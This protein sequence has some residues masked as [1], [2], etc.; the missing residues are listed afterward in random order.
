M[1]LCRPACG[2]RGEIHA[3]SRAYCGSEGEPTAGGELSSAVALA[4]TRVAEKR[5]AVPRRY[6]DAL[7][8]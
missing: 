8:S 2:L 3:S 6:A 1:S 5:V 7:S 4:P